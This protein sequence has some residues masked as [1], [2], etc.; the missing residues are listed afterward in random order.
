MRPLGS[1][2]VI[3]LLCFGCNAPSQT[4]IETP[5]DTLASEESLNESVTGEE[6]AVVCTFCHGDSLQGNDRRDGPALAGLEAWYLELQMQNFKNGIRGYPA[7]DVPGQV[8]YFSRGMLRNDATIKSLAEYISTMEPGKPMAANG[9]GE[10]PYL[11]DSPYAGLDP[12]ISANAEAGEKTYATVCVACHGTDGKG[13][14]ALGAAD[15]R[16]LSEVYLARQL[17][18]F[19][20]GIRGAHPED[21]RGQQMAAIAQILADDQTIADVVAYIS[22]L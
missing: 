14:E 10:R 9:I 16:H 3:L 17:M 19:R 5:N 6:L 11:W 18:Y 12:S 21:T 20:D 22:E 1:A 7:E 4:P 8:M 2:L 15:L 13:L